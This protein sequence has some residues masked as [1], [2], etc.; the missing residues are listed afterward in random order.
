MTTSVH[1]IVDQ[2][3]QWW[4]AYVCTREPRFLKMPTT[5]RLHAVILALHMS[6]TFLKQS[7]DPKTDMLF[8][9]PEEAFFT[10]EKYTR[11][12]K[13]R[14]SFVEPE[15]WEDYILLIGEFGRRVQ[16]S[17]TKKHLKECF[18]TLRALFHPIRNGLCEVVGWNRAGQLELRVTQ[19]G[20]RKFGVEKGEIFISAIGV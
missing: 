5:V 11:L 3:A 8:W 6:T 2:M 4:D 9:D 20:V 1:P 13:I 12:D 18:V 16:T 17:L 19:I 10:K 15:G 14:R 7:E